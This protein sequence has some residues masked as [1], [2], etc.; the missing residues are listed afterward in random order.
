MGVCRVLHVGRFHILKLCEAARDR[1]SPPLPADSHVQCRPADQ[2]QR[3]CGRQDDE[4]LPVIG[5]HCADI[6]MGNPG[7]RSGSTTPWASHGPPGA[8]PQAMVGS[9]HTKACA[10]DRAPAPAAL[11]HIVEAVNRD[12][13]DRDATPDPAPGPSPGRSSPASPSRQGR[14]GL[15]GEAPGAEDQRHPSRRLIPPEGS[16]EIS[17]RLLL[18]A[19]RAGL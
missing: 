7:G 10:R 3:E 15:A 4:E 19:A 14:L 5:I 2:P 9:F 6:P 18:A 8:G 12:V 1:A 13:A 16:A 11:S 17:E